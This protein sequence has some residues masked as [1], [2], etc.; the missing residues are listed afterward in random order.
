MLSLTGN[1]RILIFVSFFPAGLRLI[2]MTYYTCG[3]QIPRQNTDVNKWMCSVTAVAKF[4]FLEKPCAF[5][6]VGRTMIKLKLHNLNPSAPGSFVLGDLKN[7][8]SDL[9][10]WQLQD[11]CKII[12]LNYAYKDG[13]FRDLP[14]PAI[15][16]NHR[17]FIQ[18]Y[19]ITLDKFCTTFLQPKSFDI[20]NIWYF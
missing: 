10:C 9:A 13:N 6:R 3:D 20:Y 19:F 5:P 8:T 16:L 11:K 12:A 1:A 2:L 17:L 7:E 15:R 18:N 4:L 14:L